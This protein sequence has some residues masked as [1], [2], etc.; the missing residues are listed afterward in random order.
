[1]RI[2]YAR[3]STEDQSLNLQLDALRAAGCT[4]IFKEKISGKVR[5]GPKLLAALA[6]IETGDQIVVWRTCRLGRTFRHRVD[7]GD[8]LHERG[9]TIVSLTEGL[10]TSTSFGMAIYRILSIFADMEHEAIVLRTRAGLAAA[11][12]RGVKLGGRSK[13]S[14]AMIEQARRYRADGMPIDAIADGYCVSRSTL[15][16]HLQRSDRLAR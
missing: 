1:M 2:G 10:D 8:E 7:L 13:L 15:Y 5:R 11:K 14:P 3:V 9:V 16:R 12:A 6:T 4:R